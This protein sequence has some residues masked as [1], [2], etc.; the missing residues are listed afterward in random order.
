MQESEAEQSLKE[1][2]EHSPSKENKRRTGGNA[3]EKSANEKKH[4][5]RKLKG[6]ALRKEQVNP[7]ADGK[8]LKLVEDPDFQKE[9]DK[10]CRKLFGGFD[11]PTDISIEDFKQELL[12]RLGK[13]LRQFRG[14]SQLQTYLHRMAVNRLIDLSRKRKCLP[15]ETLSPRNE[16]GDARSGED[17]EVGSVAGRYCETYKNH[18]ADAEERKIM[19]HELMS[20]LSGKDRFIFTAYFVEKWLLQDIADEL[21]VSPQAVSKRLARVAEKLRSY[22]ESSVSPG[23]SPAGA[24]AESGRRPRASGSGG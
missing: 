19:V 13:N 6:S 12:D 24:Q 10:T 18:V 5:A 4:I 1:G 20:K 9:F 23:N 15:L 2:T 17:F 21:G 22:V 14:E 7:W 11:V 16:D 3:Q 8:F